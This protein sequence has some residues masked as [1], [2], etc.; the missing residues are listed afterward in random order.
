[1]TN[2]GRSHRWENLEDLGYT[3]TDKVSQTDEDVSSSGSGTSGDLGINSE[4]PLWAEDAI[5]P[6]LSHPYPEDTSRVHQRLTHLENEAVQW[7]KLHW[8]VTKA[9]EMMEV[10][11]TYGLFMTVNNLNTEINEMQS[12][13]DKIR[14][15]IPKDLSGEVTK[16]QSP[17]TEN[18][19]AAR[20]PGMKEKYIVVSQ[21][22][23]G[24]LALAAIGFGAVAQNQNIGLIAT[25]MA[26]LFIALSFGGVIAERFQMEKG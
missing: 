20:I 11:S 3:G 12:E 1:M 5:Y 24:L 2:T 23:F 8:E 14:S 10:E 25:L 26:P 21:I 15:M 13:I 7:Q 17:N 19:E 16:G 18:L 9:Q 4:E 22:A 6:G